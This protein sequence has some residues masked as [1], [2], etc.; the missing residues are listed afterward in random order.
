MR[1]SDWSSDVCSSDL[2]GFCLV[3]VGAAEAAPAKGSRSRGY[4]PDAREWKSKDV[5]ED[6]EPSGASA[7]TRQLAST[8]KWTDA[9][10]RSAAGS[11]RITA[12]CRGTNASCGSRTWSRRGGGDLAMGSV[13]RAGARGGKT[14]HC[15]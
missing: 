14:A 3:L 1:I 13:A 4:A 11:S 12:A 15:G 5:R 6:K 10:V 7:T 2:P 8:P 9:R